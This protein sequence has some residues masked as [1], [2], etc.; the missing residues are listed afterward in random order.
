LVRLVFV[1]ELEFTG[2]TAER[3]LSSLI[4]AA[5]AATAD[6]EKSE[7]ELMSAPTVIINKERIAQIINLF[8]PIASE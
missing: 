2:A 1:L 4:D 6:G 5:A 8:V 3:F 7:A